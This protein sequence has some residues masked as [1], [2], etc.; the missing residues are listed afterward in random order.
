MP[1]KLQK[2][3]IPPDSC[4]HIDRVQELVVSLSTET[5]EE[6]RNGYSKIIE[7]ELELIRTINSQLREASKVWYDRY[8]KK[9]GN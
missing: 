1:R 8:N 9:G 3:N 2:P 4:G 5:D 6:M 7:E